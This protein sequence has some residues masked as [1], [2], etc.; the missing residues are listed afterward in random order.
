MPPVTAGANHVYVVPA[1]TLPF[2]PLTG[3]TVNAT[4]LQVAAVIFVTAGLGFTVTV[5]VNV[6]PVQVAV[7]GV[8]V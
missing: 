1:G 7:A 6:E 8:T 3:V 4:P 2:T 5:T